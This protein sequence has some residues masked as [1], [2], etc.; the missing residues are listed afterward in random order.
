ME[1]SPRLSYRGT[2]GR[3]DFLY[4]GFGASIS[5][6]ALSADPTD[7]QHSLQQGEQKLPI[8]INRE[9]PPLQHLPFTDFF[10]G[11]EKVNA[12][13][14]VF[15]EETDAILSE[16]KVS[17]ISLRFMYMGIRDEDG[18]IIVGTHHLRHSDTRTLYLDIVHELFHIKQWR[19][20]SER[21]GEEHRKFM[22][23]WS[24]YFSSPIEVPAY[25]HTVREAE[26]IGMPREE[27]VEHLKM[28]PTPP[29]A[30]ARF[31]KAMELQRGPRSAKKATL[32]VRISRKAPVPLFPF[33]DYFKGFEK[34]AAVRA[35]LGQKTVRFL[36]SLRVEFVHNSFMRV[37]PNGEDG[38][39]VVGAPYLKSTD[40]T[41]IYLD[42]LVCLSLMSRASR[43]PTASGTS[44]G[45]YPDIKDL[46][47]SYRFMLKEARR[48]RVPHARV[49]ERLN[50]P[51]F[52][53]DPADHEK[54]LRKL[55]LS[56]SKERPS[57]R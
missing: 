8:R 42:V 34:A 29:E 5:A 50:V 38:H 30:F 35:L 20:D 37:I 12:V 54:F 25:R 53:M 22:G 4:L 48:L 17:F 44:E 33:T 11:F 51:R 15:G 19:E 14:S 28:G 55:G 9:T 46:V 47:E 21:F 52:L 49:M 39:L 3:F 16:L 18:S 26:R 27:I 40:P 2:T 23:D 41:S 10:R 57:R 24:L 6:T 56:D 45:G 31:L 36:G 7:R 43:E 32:P 1:G 13:R